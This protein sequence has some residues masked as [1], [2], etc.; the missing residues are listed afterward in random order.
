MAASRTRERLRSSSFCRV[1]CTSVTAVSGYMRGAVGRAAGT[2]AARAGASPGARAERCR[3][4][5]RKGVEELLPAVFAGRLATVWCDRHTPFDPYISPTESVASTHAA[6]IY[7]PRR[8]PAQ[9]SSAELA[10]WP[11]R[12]LTHRLKRH[13]HAC[14]RPAARGPY[15]LDAA[16]SKRATSRTSQLSSM[17]CR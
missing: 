15:M 12:P 1:A 10:I 6:V 14:R 5:P 13:Y 4:R 9:L 3:A 2:G 16:R 8:R 17:P 11:A 7:G